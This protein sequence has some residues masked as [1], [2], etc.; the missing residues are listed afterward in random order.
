MDNLMIFQGA[1]LLPFMWLALYALLL[2][3][4]VWVP[5]GLPIRSLK[6]LLGLLFAVYGWLLYQ[7][8]T[9]TLDFPG[10]VEVPGIYDFP[11]EFIFTPAM[12]CAALVMI[13]ILSV[14]VK[15]SQSY[16]HKEVG[17]HRFFFLFSVFIAAF[18]VVVFADNIDVLFVG[19]E[20]IG[21]TSVLLI[22]FY[23]ARE[24]T[25]KNSWW[26]ISSYRF[27]DV[28]LL[29]STALAH[30][31]FHTTNITLL[32]DPNN[33]VAHHGEHAFWLAPLAFCLFFASL[34]KAAQLPFTSWITRAMEGP[35]PSSALYYGALSIGLGPV[36]LLK[37]QGLLL[38]FTWLQ[39]LIIAVGGLTALYT[40]LVAKTRS[41]AK[42]ILAL[43]AVFEI[44]IMVVE[45]GLG[46]RKWVLF[47]FAANAFLRVFQFLRSMNAIHDFYDNPLFYRGAPHRPPPAVLK[48][49]PQSFQK[50]LYYN[51]MN[52][53]GLDGFWSNVVVGP[54]LSLLK[55][56][57][58]WENRMV[59]GGDAIP[60]PEAG[61]SK[62]G[63]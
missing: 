38:S 50:H 10:W 6:I 4:R 53:F 51:A 5:E 15:Y 27:C 37:F 35:T 52:G 61:L 48:W 25:A 3:C 9:L 30:Y 24:H 14:L 49:L 62:A 11:L 45:V 2:L 20:L 58:H 32:N 42:S 33:L 57:N 7:G 26:A 16:L 8:G 36:L 13:F 22:N 54:T 18:P 34:A 28:G 29:A 41:D 39:L 17:Y 12:G 19:W 43:S 1:M 56:I 44:S 46:L 60:H 55:K 63:E 47:H 31:A 40:F 21:V 23:E 59:L